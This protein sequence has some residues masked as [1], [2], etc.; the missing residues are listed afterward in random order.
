MEKTHRSS[1]REKK[2]KKEDIN[3]ENYPGK[4]IIE[5]RNRAHSPFGEYILRYDKG[6]FQQR[7]YY[8]LDKKYGFYILYFNGSCF[9]TIPK[10]KSAEEDQESVNKRLY[11]KINL[12]ALYQLELVNDKSK[13]REITLEGKIHIFEK[14]QVL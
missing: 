9:G 1:I 11:E 6:I 13:G 2:V 8:E 10:G 14:K 3:D 7:I 4:L 12:E 5:W